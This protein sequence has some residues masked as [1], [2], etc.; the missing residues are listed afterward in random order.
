[1]R[2]SNHIAV[3]IAAVAVLILP[4]FYAGFEENSVAEIINNPQ[5]NEAS[6]QCTDPA[7]I[8]LD[9]KE[10]V[11][12]ACKAVYIEYRASIDERESEL[13]EGQIAMGDI[14]MRV[15]MQV[16]GEPD[17]K[18][19]P[20]IIALHGG[21][22]SDTPTMND[23]QWAQMKEYYKGSVTN[24]VYITPRGIRDTW[25]THFNP[26][27]YVFYDRIIE[28][29]VAFYNVD[30]DRVYLLG[31]S[32][33]GD[34]VYAISPRMADRFAAVN[35]SAGH[36]NGVSIVNL[37]HLPI[38]LQVG[39]NDAA[40]QRNT[41]TAEYDA[42][43]KQAAITY[44]GGYTHTTLV[45]IGMPHNFYDND[46]S[47]Q[48]VAADVKA[49]LETG[50]GGTIMA[51]T[52]AVR[53]TGAY[54]R[55]ANPVRVVWE[56]ETNAS[57]RSVHS[58]YWLGRSENL[59]QGII[60]ANYKSEANRITV[61]SCTAESG[62]LKIYLTASMVDLFAP[63]TV[64]FCGAISVVTVTPALKVMRDT[65][66]ERGDPEMIYAAVI[67]VDVATGAIAGIDE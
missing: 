38:I 12:T 57:E 22:S 62:V 34:G 53:L 21:G 3:L 20:M 54:T 47:E 31:F 55:E 48:P 4:S 13:A 1:M 46:S 51:D 43:L 56:V 10:N 27:S 11:I 16:I 41:V 50:C 65:A 28:D 8:V 36:P 17:E 44:G 2:L 9:T 37:Y 52:N 67:E 23:S 30:P 40:Y 25:D 32:A 19:Y 26:E 66:Q 35:M 39:E 61:E 42:L 5:S 29:A 18:G 49:W 45:H 60:V 6:N 7:S 58:F 64:D 63:V 14:T 33:G 15:D 24:G 59:D